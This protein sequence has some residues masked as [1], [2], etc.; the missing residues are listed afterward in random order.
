V[1]GGSWLRFAA[2]RRRAEGD[3][4]PGHELGTTGEVAIER[5]DQ[6]LEA[7]PVVVGDAGETHLDAAD[8]E[9]LEDV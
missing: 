4:K 1:T 8:L 3:V 9:A 5:E 2:L 7:P 6:M